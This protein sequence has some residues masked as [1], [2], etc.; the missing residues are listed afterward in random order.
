MLSLKFKSMNLFACEFLRLQHQYLGSQRMLKGLWKIAIFYKIPS[1]MLFLC[2]KF[3][4]GMLDVMP[5]PLKVGEQMKQ[6][7]EF[8]GVEL[9]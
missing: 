2:E 5:A 6:P 3:P 9:G 4:H 1:S 7:A 8:W